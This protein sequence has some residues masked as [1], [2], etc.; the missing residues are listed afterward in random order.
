[1]NN[2]FSTSDV[3]KLTGYCEATIRM[4][5][6][7]GIIEG[8]KFKHTD[9]AWFFTESTVRQLLKKAGKPADIHIIPSSCNHPDFEAKDSYTT[10]Q[11][12]ELLEIGLSSARKYAKNGHIPAGKIPPVDGNFIGLPINRW[13]W[14]Y[15]K[16]S[17]DKLVQARTNNSTDLLNYNL[18]YLLTQ[19]AK[20]KTMC[21]M[22]VTSATS[23]AKTEIKHVHAMT[24]I[25][26]ISS[27]IKHLSKHFDG[28]VPEALIIKYVAETLKVDKNAVLGF[29]RGHKGVWSATT[30]K[31]TYGEELIT[32]SLDDPEI[33]RNEIRK[34]E[35][36]EVKT[37]QVKISVPSHV[38]NLTTRLEYR[39]N[40]VEELLK[41][42]GMY[43][44][45]QDCYSEKAGD[46][47]DEIATRVENNLVSIFQFKHVGTEE[48][49]NCEY[50][51]YQNDRIGL[52]ITRGKTY[53]AFTKLRFC[54]IDKSDIT[55]EVANGI[56]ILSQLH[57]KL[58]FVK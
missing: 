28:E 14:R 52:Q 36:I 11:V 24:Y 9:N 19:P 3:V 31:N 12:C 51:C 47:L 23:K 26:A 42:K 8:V 32:Y 50:I 16:K 48:D 18:P 46:L 4:Y 29:L 1:M 34:A 22:T 5:A 2:H 38:P 44:W 37:P 49:S 56:E 57:P 39:Y 15:D 25:S 27:N 58:C 40:D 53:G 17:V 20:E 10:E 54:S 7:T 30:V 33:R 43:D 55:G 35:G 41:A 45:K 6:Q 13:H 21:T